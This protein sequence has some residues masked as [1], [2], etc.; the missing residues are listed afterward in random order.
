MFLRLS[1]FS[2]KRIDNFYAAL[3]RFAVLV[4]FAEIRDPK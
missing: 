4:L 1:F 3:R 2:L